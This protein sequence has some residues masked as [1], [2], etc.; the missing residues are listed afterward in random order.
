MFHESGKQLSVG[1]AVIARMRGF[2]PWPGR[3][4]SI[5]PKSKRINCYFFGTHNTGPVGS[6]NIMP[7]DG[8]R[9]TIRLVV[10]RSP[11]GYVKGVKEIEIEYGVPEE[12][13]CLNEFKSIN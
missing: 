10:L 1:D 12:L 5:M 7:F 9:E 6:K 8:A 2:H 13:S 4:Q 11:K 3:I